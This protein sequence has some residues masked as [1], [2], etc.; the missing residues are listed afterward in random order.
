MPFLARALHAM[1]PAGPA[2]TMRTSTLLSLDVTTFDIFLM[3][4]KLAGG[5]HDTVKEEDGTEVEKII[6]VQKA[7]LRGMRSTGEQEAI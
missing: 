1:T 3:P 6:K 5:L 4:C 2:P 7:E